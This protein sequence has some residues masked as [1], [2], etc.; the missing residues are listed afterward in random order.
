MGAVMT[1]DQRAEK[2]STISKREIERRK[3]FA[4]MV[5]KEMAKPLAE[6]NMD[7]SRWTNGLP[8]TIDG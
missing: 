2:H 4:E 3:A 6:R 5:G 8:G 1:G 7:F